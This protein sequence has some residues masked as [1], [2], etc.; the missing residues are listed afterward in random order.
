MDRSSWICDSRAD[1]IRGGM[2]ILGGWLDSNG[3][4]I[5]ESYT[6]PGMAH[7][8]P[9]STGN[10]PSECGASG[11]FLLDVGISSSYHIA[12]FFGLVDG[13]L[14]KE[15]QADGERLGQHP[16]FSPA[17]ENVTS[18]APYVHEGE[19]LGPE[20]AEDPKFSQSSKLPI[21]VGAVIRNALTAAGLMRRT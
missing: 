11:P 6:I 19:I 15:T 16:P 4:E 13:N 2:V 3:V 5:I 14:E 7:G 20:S 17:K 12:K 9:L 18:V 10:A 21:D 8:T 1:S